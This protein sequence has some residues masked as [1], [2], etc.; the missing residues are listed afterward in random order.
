MNAP[1]RLINCVKPVV[2]ELMVFMH[3]LHA[4][5]TLMYRQ[6]VRWPSSS[7]VGM[8]SM[9]LAQTQVLDAGR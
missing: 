8:A 9:S 4:L 2:Y 7:C 3:Q 5:V 1:C 6:L